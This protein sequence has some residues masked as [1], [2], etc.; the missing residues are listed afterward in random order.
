MSAL[1]HKDNANAAIV[2]AVREARA[3]GERAAMKRC[4]CSSECQADE[5]NYPPIPDDGYADGLRDGKL[6]GERAAT[7]RICS[8]LESNIDRVNGYD[9]VSK[10]ARWYDAGR[11]EALTHLL[12]VIREGRA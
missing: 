8:I 6:M 1:V 12:S 10:H 4:I 2:L 5:H 7:E 9:K 11:A 3:E